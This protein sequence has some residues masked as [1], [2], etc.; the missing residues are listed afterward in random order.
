MKSK[1][2]KVAA[3]LAAAVIITLAALPYMVDIDRFRP[4]LEST[5]SSSLGR[6]VHVGHMQLSLLS[7]G[8]RVDQVSIADD[9]AYST[10]TFLQAKSLGVGVSLVSL[11]F[12]RSLHVTSLTLDEP[13]MTAIQSENGGWNFATIGGSSKSEDDPAKGGVASS[14]VSSIVLDHLKISNAT[15]EVTPNGGQPTTLKNIDV[16]LKNASFDSAMS[17]ALSAHTDAGQIDVKGEAGPMNR[18]NPDQ[19]PFHATVKAKKADLAQI[20]SLGKSSGLSGILNLD[21]TVSSDGRTIHS[22]GKATADKLRLVSG[23][24]AARQTISVKYSTD[25]SVAKKTGVIRNGVI[26]TGKGS[27]TL[28]GSYDARGKNVIVHMKIA[29]NQVP[30]DSVEGVLPAIGVV[31][32]GGSKIRGGTVNANL[33]LDGPADRVVTSGNVQI[34]NAHLAGFD[35]AS[36]L[37]SLPGMSAAKGSTDLSISTLGTGLRIGPQGTHISGFNGE[38]AGIGSIT[39]DGDISN[40]NHLQFKMVAHVASNGAVRYGLNHVGLKNVPNEVPFQVVGTTSMPVIIP[41]LSGMAKN[42]AKAAAKETAKSEFK[43][44]VEKVT[45]NPVPTETKSTSTT[46]IIPAAEKTPVSTSQ[47]QANTKKAGFFHKLFGHK[48]KH[49]AANSAQLTAR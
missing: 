38:F 3:I 40:D 41:D 21:G 25:Y 42:T 48:D 14:A 31:L 35:L 39:G 13:Q 43:K 27:A 11:I 9:P 49:A 6:E 18:E 32:P 30:L 12:S 16:E 2:M 22:E 10:N 15:I 36:K 47:Q 7:G 5:L 1:G 44:L 29:G 20:A 28:S 46:G 8:A 19:T 45:K 4:E 17:F 23:A 24:Q 34:A 26:D 37:S 33:A